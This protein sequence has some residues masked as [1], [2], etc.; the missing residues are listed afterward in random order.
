MDQG[1]RPQGRISLDQF[2]SKSLQRAEDLQ[3]RLARLP[4]LNQLADAITSARAAAGEGAGGG[5]A[6]CGSEGTDC[7]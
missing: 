6:C 1:A 4:S 5:G 7:H 2:L 3:R